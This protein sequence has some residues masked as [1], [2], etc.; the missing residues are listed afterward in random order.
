MRLNFLANRGPI[1]PFERCASS[2][3]LSGH[4]DGP[5]KRLLIATDFS[6][7]SERAFAYAI[8]MAAQNRAEIVLLHVFEPVP[9]ELKV[10]ESGFVDPS[11]RERASEELS[12]WRRRVPHELTATAV[13]REAKAAHEEILLAAIE[14]DV[15]LIVM[16]RQ[17]RKGLG[18]LIHSSTAK[19][20]LKHATCAVLV[21]APGPGTLAQ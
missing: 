5:L 7:A 20:V 19:Y 2:V 3:Q 11:F 9:P 4:A 21:T 8:S 15:D 18:R 17:G 6:E 13:F 14:F 16:G 12:E 1:A 10:L